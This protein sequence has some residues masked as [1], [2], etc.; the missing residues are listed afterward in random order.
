MAMMS[1]SVG[2]RN[3]RDSEAD[4]ETQIFVRPPL[5]WDRVMVLHIMKQL[6]KRPARIVLPKRKASLVPPRDEPNVFLTPHMGS[7]T[8]ETRNAMGFR[9]LDNI[10]AVTA[11][12][13][14]IDPLWS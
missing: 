9:A 6:E 5:A 7:A 12:K 3:P 8:L 2:R 14:A 11:G 13:P 4:V 1:A 10:A